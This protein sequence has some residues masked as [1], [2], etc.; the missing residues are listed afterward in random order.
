M[1]IL[2]KSYL[3]C[4][5]K[6]NLIQLL[7]CDF[8]ASKIIINNDNDNDNDNDNEDDDDNVIC[9]I[10]KV[11]ISFCNKSMRKIIWDLNVNTDRL[12]SY[13]YM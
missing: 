11:C 3:Y 6:F 12:H 13:M 7:S 1:H 2:A 5:V 4:F 9:F 10:I 8:H